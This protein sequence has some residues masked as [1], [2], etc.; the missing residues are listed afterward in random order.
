MKRS[1]FYPLLATFL[2]G[3]IGSNR[4]LIQAGLCDV[5]GRDGGF[6]RSGARRLELC[7]GVRTE[8]GIGDGGGLYGWVWGA[9]G[10][11]GE[12]IKGKVFVVAVVTGW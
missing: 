5:N 11:H 6:Q 2:S 4:P 3:G 12:D 7:G 9:V 8:G 1:L 10:E